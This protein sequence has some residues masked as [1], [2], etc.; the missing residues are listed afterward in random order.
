[1]EAL[2]NEGKKDKAKK[3]IDLAMAKMPVDY[4]EYY[5]LLEPFANGY[6]QLGQKEEAR[7][8]LDKLITK[9]QE[10]LIFYRG[11]SVGDQS[12]IAVDIVTAIERYRSL[13]WVMKDNGD[14]AYYNAAKVKFNEFNQK[15]ARFKRDKE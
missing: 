11:L 13:L 5:T 14:T 7:K 10:N 6:Y 1:M 15:A 9:Y 2:I 4:Y 12:N 8:L 3:V